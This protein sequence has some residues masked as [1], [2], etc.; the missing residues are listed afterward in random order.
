ML[1]ITVFLGYQRNWSRASLNGLSGEPWPAPGIRY[2]ARGRI[3][4]YPL[5]EVMGFSGFHSIKGTMFLQVVI[6]MR[7]YLGWWVGGSR[8]WAQ[9]Q[10][11]R[12]LPSSIWHW[13][14]H[15]CPHWLFLSSLRWQRLRWEVWSL[16]TVVWQEFCPCSPPLL[17][18][19]PS[20]LKQM[21]NVAIVWF[22]C[23]LIGDFKTKH[24]TTK[25]MQKTG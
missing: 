2:T 17:S 7:Q 21:N 25:H 15:L 24:T 3:W 5:G 10:P 11:T 1:H 16:H 4:F 22:L 19:I 12:G 13:L 23:L 20:W 18:F 6:C 9:N 8:K 14:W